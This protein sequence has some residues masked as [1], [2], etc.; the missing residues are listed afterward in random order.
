MC[1]NC[2]SSKEHIIIIG[3]HLIPLKSLP[4]AVVMNEIDI[5]YLLLLIVV[6]KLKRIGITISLY[7]KSND[8][9]VKKKESKKSNTKN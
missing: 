6:S 7:N 2:S 8:R 1:E 5:L 9:G 4:N 3:T